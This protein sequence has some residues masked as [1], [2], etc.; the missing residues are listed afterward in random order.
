MHWFQMGNHWKA[1]D[2]VGLLIC[3][4]TFFQDIRYLK[5][6]IIVKWS[7]T[8]VDYIHAA[9]M[10]TLWKRF[11]FHFC[12]PN[13]AG[14]LRISLW[15]S[16]QMLAMPN[17]GYLL[18]LKLFIW[19]WLVLTRIVTIYCNLKGDIEGVPNHM[20]KTTI[21]DLHSV[22]CI[23]ENSLYDLKQRGWSAKGGPRPE[24]QPTLMSLKSVGERLYTLSVRHTCQHYDLRPKP[25]SSSNPISVTASLNSLLECFIIVSDVNAKC[26]YSSIPVN[27]LRLR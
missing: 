18:A 7:L 12:F 23:W 14:S 4:P 20:N 21:G 19:V 10:T 3:V 17:L 2:N 24:K 27:T 11:A 13:L 26:Q 5:K 22:A 25:P 6:I 1:G 16:I 15:S 8:P 9:F